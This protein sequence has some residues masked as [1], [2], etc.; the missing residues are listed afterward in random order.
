M[1][2]TRFSESSEG[3]QQTYL[4]VAEAVL[5]SAA[6]PLKAREIVERGIERGLFSDHVMGRT[7]EKSMQARLSVDILNRGEKS[8]FVRVSRGRFT[9]RSKLSNPDRSNDSLVDSDTQTEY[10][11]PRRTLRFPAEEVLCVNESEFRQTLTFQGIET[12]TDQLLPRLLGASTTQYILRSEA[13]NRDDAKQFI[14]YVLVQSGQRV[15][16]F[17]R[18]YLSR[19]AE[20]LRGSK[21]IGF[22]GHVTAADDDILSHVDRG[23]SAASTTSLICW[24]DPRQ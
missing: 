12:D 22:G 10:I 4:R 7:P 6:L 18:S 14:T 9:L 15:L 13:E 20:F 1:H 16:C 11:A 3:E 21:C 8:K 17:R 2:Q 19:A 5:A 24:D 23:L